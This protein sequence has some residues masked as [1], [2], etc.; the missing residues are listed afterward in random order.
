[1]GFRS[2]S[3]RERLREEI[4]DQWAVLELLGEVELERLAGDRAGGREIRSLGAD[5][6]FSQSRRGGE[7]GGCQSEQ[8]HAHW[9]HLPST[10]DEWVRGPLSARRS[11]ARGSARQDCRRTRPQA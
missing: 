1:M 2:A 5:G 6:E 7:S 10:N 8:K 4:E 3:A 11:K 9:S